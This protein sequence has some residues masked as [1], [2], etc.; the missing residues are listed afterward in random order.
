[1]PL[2]WVVMVPHQCE[3]DH[4]NPHY[5]TLTGRKAATGFEST[6]QI[7]ELMARGDF[8]RAVKLS[9]QAVGWYED[10][11]AEWQQSRPR[12]KGGAAPRERKRRQTSTTEAA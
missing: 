3:H 10:E 4:G 1:M 2:N 5:S 12:A 11:I 6:S 7:Y 8:P 9:A